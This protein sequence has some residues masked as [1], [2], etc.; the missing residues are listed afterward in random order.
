MAVHLA[1][2]L[3][4]FLARSASARSAMSAATSDILACYEKGEQGGKEEGAVCARARR[5]ERVGKTVGACRGKR[6]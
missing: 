3:A 1:P 5:E 6:R 2:F 4:L